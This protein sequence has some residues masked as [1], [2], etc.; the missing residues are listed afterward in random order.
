VLADRAQVNWLRSRTVQGREHCPPLDESLT[1]AKVR[2]IRHDRAWPQI[3]NQLLWGWTD[4]AERKL[5]LPLEQD[6]AHLDAEHPHR[7]KIEG[8]I[9]AARAWAA[10]HPEGIERELV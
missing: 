5:V 9:S 1:D 2:G 10:E 3:T 7:L 4:E 6:I 8:Y